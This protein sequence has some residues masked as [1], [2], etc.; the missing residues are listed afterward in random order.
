MHKKI[1][2]SNRN[3]SLVFMLFVSGVSGCKS[4]DRFFHRDNLIEV[5][6]GKID[7]KIARCYEKND[8]VF[9]FN[10]IDIYN[11]DGR[12]EE[13]FIDDSEEGGKPGADGRIDFYLKREKNR[14]RVYTHKYVIDESG[15]MIYGNGIVSKELMEL[16]KNKLV[17]S[18]AR[19]I[20]LLEKIKR[21]KKEELNK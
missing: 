9:R 10:R 20:D 8:N 17:S 14:S 21:K 3:L 7:N 6:K 5:Y 12:L 18:N 19:Y 2:W 13:I 1:S 16:S 15:K 11:I 4:I